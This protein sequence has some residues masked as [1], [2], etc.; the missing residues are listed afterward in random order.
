MVSISLHYWAGARA[1]AGVDDEVIEADTVAAALR[2]A[3]QEHD[4]PHFER[5]L[6]ASSLL[7]DGLTARPAD[8]DRFGTSRSELRSCRRSR[9]GPSAFTHFVRLR[10]HSVKPGGSARSTVARSRQGLRRVPSASC[11][12]VA[13]CPERLASVRACRRTADPALR[14]TRP[15]CRSVNLPPLF[16]MWTSV[17]SSEI[18]AWGAERPPLVFPRDNSACVDAAA[19]SPPR[20][21][22]RPHG[23]VIVSVASNVVRRPAKSG[24][25]LR[26]SAAR[27]C[28]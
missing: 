21:R 19:R 23:F 7:I 15:A 3:T 1:A 17:L 18:A 20:G 14:P 12:A 6:R 5:V 9:A 16:S 13:S 26:S 25:A 22:S 28:W 11:R 4:D 2:W 8:L 10:A 24:Y 27:C